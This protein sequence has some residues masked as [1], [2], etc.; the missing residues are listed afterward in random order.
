MIDEK[1]L[2]AFEQLKGL[3]GEHQRHFRDL[4]VSCALWKL[5][6]KLKLIAIDR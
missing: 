1:V 5:E 6:K 2:P 4:I 3:H